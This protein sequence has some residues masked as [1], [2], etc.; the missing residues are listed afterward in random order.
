MPRILLK[1]LFGKIKPNAAPGHGITN[2]YEFV[3]V[4]GSEIRSN[5][6]YT[7][8]HITTSGAKCTKPIKLLCQD[9]ADFL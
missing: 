4:F 9:V 6:T 2:A 8:N 1:Y 3:I 7:K 5:K